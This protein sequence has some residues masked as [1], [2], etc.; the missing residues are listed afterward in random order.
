MS[1]GLHQDT[2]GNQLALY[3]EH[4]SLY[5][6]GA[7]AH[8]EL[9]DVNQQHVMRS[10]PNVYDWWLA[11]VYVEDGCYN[12]TLSQQTIQIDNIDLNYA[13]AIVVLGNND[14]YGVEDKFHYDVTF[15]DVGLAL[16]NAT[17]AGVTWEAYTWGDNAH[18]IV[19][20]TAASALQFDLINLHD[21]GITSAAQ[22]TL[23]GVTLGSD[24]GSVTS[25]G[26][27]IVQSVAFSYDD[28]VGHELHAVLNKLYVQL[29]PVL[30]GSLL[31]TDTAFWQH[32][33]VD[34]AA[35]VWTWV[36]QYVLHLQMET[37]G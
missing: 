23:D 34:Q 1:V 21:L 33:Q 26:D 12:S 32:N 14:T 2:G 4:V 18:A 28:G 3:G 20:D 6:M 9:I 35:Q 36:E 29:D 15:S 30:S 8:I 11:D 37:L 5:D 16:N 17:L 27:H 24:F 31:Q 25:T 10:G 22:L 19:H 13:Q 7:D